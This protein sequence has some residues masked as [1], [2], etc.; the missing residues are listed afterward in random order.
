M[1]AAT[2]VHAPSRYGPHFPNL[3]RSERTKFRTLRSTW[4]SLG[5]A[6]V[7]SVGISIL[8][9]SVYVANWS[10][11][12]AQDKADFVNNTI[13][14]IVQPAFEFS[15]LVIA[16]LGV[17]MMASE[18]STGMVKSTMLAAPRR[19]PALAAKAVVLA[20]TVFVLAEALA[21][22]AFAIDS[23]IVH[24]R[25][26]ITLG[27]P[28]TLRALLGFG[29]VMTMVALIGLALGALLRHTAAGITA[30]LGLNLALPGLLLLIPGSTG[31]HLSDAMPYSSGQFIMQR[32][33]DSRVSYGPWT[34][35]GITAAWTF[36]LLTAAFVAVKR[37]DV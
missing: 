24:S 2:I 22:I 20:V 36:V 31:R 30:A 32:T 10:S 18:H 37:R 21:L 12:T 28:G 25:A 26:P 33:L 29:V 34:G 8:A 13:G 23:A 11:H 6:T 9:C 35:L 5:I 15:A 4:W 27:T 7:L 16:V 1:T 17:M 3:L 14:L 19:T